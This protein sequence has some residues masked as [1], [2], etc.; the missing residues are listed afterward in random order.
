MVP[1]A[2]SAAARDLKGEVLLAE[3]DGGELSAVW[4]R[5]D[6]GAQIVARGAALAEA[7]DAGVQFKL[8]QRLDGEM[9]GVEALVRY[10]RFLQLVDGGRGAASAVRA[11]DVATARER[12]AALGGRGK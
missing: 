1:V 9:K 2:L 8:A 6:D 11:A 12:V 4:Y 5:S 10:E 3:M 7:G